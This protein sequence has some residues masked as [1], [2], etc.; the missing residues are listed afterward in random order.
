MKDFSI[1]AEIFQK[2]KLAESGVGRW[3]T[4]LTHQINRLQ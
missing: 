1:R 3:I 2:E 4:G